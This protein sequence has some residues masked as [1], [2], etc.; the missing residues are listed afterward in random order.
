MY[1]YRLPLPTKSTPDRITATLGDLMRLWVRSMKKRR[2]KG[3]LKKKGQRFS[4]AHTCIDEGF[5]LAGKINTIPFQ[6]RKKQLHVR[7]ASVQDRLHRPIPF[8]VK[9]VS[10]FPFKALMT[11]YHHQHVHQGCFV[12]LSQAHLQYSAEDL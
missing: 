10:T 6:E 3:H 5:V 1:L 9:L 8:R 11:R 4:E 2:F 12:Q 7:S